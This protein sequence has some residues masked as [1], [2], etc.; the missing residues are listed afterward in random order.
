MMYQLPFQVLSVLKFCKPVT[1]LLLSKKFV[2]TCRAQTSLSRI[3]IEDRIQNQNLF[4]SHSIRSLVTDVTQ[5]SCKDNS[6]DNLLPA[7][8]SSDI[9][10]SQYVEEEINIIGRDVPA[11]LLQFNDYPWPQKIKDSIRFKGFSNPTCI[12]SQAWSIALE[13]RDLVAIAKTGS[14]KTWGY[15]L[16][17]FVHIDNRKVNDSRTKNPLVLVI[18]PTRELTQQ[19]EKVCKEFDFYSVVSLFGGASR[20]VQADSLKIYSPQIIIATP[21]RLNDF[22]DANIINLRDVGYFVIDEADRMLDMGFEPQITR[23]IGKLPTH[24]QTLMWSATWPKEVQDLAQ[25]FLNDF[26]Q[27]TV[28]STDLHANPNITQFIELCEPYNKEEKLLS[29]VSEI[30]KSTKISSTNKILIFAETK[31]KVD[32]LSRFLNSR[33]YLSLAIHGD[34]TQSAR[35]FVINEYRRGKRQIL[36]ATD[37]ASRGLDVNDINYVINYDMPKTAEDYVHRI[38]RTARQSKKGTSYS[39]FTLDDI[40]LAKDLVNIL[41]TNNQYIDPRLEDLAKR[42]QK[43]LNREAQRG[44]Q[45]YS[46]YIDV[47]NPKYF[48]NFRKKNYR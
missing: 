15:M 19:I 41:K 37:V 14:G 26:I 29:L 3:L 2:S 23:I 31:R 33:G 45:R 25:N 39:L 6:D 4:H 47:K 44:Y 17:A 27:I 8:V 16:P 48:S 22:L 32:F 28:G 36:I 40:R 30:V 46:S 35:D 9:S 10:D 12:Q 5:L 42:S 43:E 20:N 1:R 18:A 38:G 11:P 7:L 21:G 34:K 24:K 13:G